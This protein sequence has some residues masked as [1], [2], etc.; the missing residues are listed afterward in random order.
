MPF[1]T[2]QLD[3]FS[4]AFAE[5]L[6]TAYPEWVAYARVDIAEDGETP[7]LVVEV[8]SPCSKDGSLE[9]IVYTEDTEVIVNFAHYHSHFGWPPDDSDMTRDAL[10]FIAAILS[11]EIAA[12]SGWN[13]DKWA[14]SWLI[15]KGEAIAPPKNMPIME[16]I[17]IRS[18]QGTLNQDMA[19][20]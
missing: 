2:A 16:S 18:W 15:H 12:A 6:F 10:T 9:L 1:D 13:G 4:G 19:C 7:D 14:G 5:A 11:E 17:R 3:G 20:S 8:P